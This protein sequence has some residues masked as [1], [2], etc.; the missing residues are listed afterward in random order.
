MNA[1]Y[2][3]ASSAYAPGKYEIRL[4]YYTNAK[5]NHANGAHYKPGK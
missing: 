4:D 5:N 1:G 2:A 3:Q